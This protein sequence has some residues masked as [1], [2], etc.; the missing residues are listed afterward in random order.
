MKKKRGDVKKEIKE[1]KKKTNKK[2]REATTR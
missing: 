2:K 1:V